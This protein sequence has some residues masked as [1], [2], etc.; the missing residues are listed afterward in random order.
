MGCQCEN[1]KSNLLTNEFRLKNVRS[2]KFNQKQVLQDNDCFDVNNN[3]IS[4][5]NG[6]SE[7]NVNLKKEIDN[8][9]NYSTENESMP[10]SERDLIDG[11]KFLYYINRVRESPK[12]YCDYILKY[13]SM[14][15]YKENRYYLTIRNKTFINLNK[16]PEAF[17]SAIEFID[18]Q[19]KLHLL[20][21]SNELSLPFPY[22][23]PSLA[24]N[25]NYLQVII[26]EK[27]KELKASYDIINF[28]YDQMIYDPKLAVMLQVIDDTNSGY[29]RRKNIFSTQAEYIGISGGKIN[30]NMYCFYYLFANKRCK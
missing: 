17:S 2:N 24:V 14:I 6:L 26:F 23:N 29:L 19:K 9:Q 28:H 7:I 15:M 22:F 27:A 5:M 20:T 16:G 21:L 25:Q 12:V 13:K 8:H 30:S 4:N 18:K 11:E 1:Q 10:P 3:G